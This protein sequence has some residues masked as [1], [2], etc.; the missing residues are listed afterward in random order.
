MVKNQPYLLKRYSAYGKKNFKKVKLFCLNL[1]DFLQSLPLKTTMNRVSDTE[2]TQF[3][4]YHSRLFENL[5]V[6]HEFS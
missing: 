5:A 3:Q 2:I 4:V 6:E 1:N